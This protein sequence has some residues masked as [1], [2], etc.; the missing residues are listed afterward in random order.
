[1][2]SNSP[3]TKFTQQRISRDG[4]ILLSIG[5]VVGLALGLLIGW[6]WWPVDWQGGSIGTA[7][8][9]ERISYA[10]AVADAYAPY[11][12]QE[13]L[14]VAGQRLA[15]L[16]DNRDEII[17]QAIEYY[18]TQPDGSIQAANLAALASAL[19]SGA[20]LL[21]TQQ[22]ATGEAAPAATAVAT[23]VVTA[24]ATPIADTPQQDNGWGG[25]AR[26]L[27][28]LA[29]LALIGFGGYVLWMLA[30][31]RPLIGGD[32][33]T[34]PGSVPPEPP[35]NATRSTISGFDSGQATR[36][37]SSYA[38]AQANA[39]RV[40]PVQPTAGAPTEPFLHEDAVDDTV[41][42]TYATASAATSA[43]PAAAPAPERPAAVPPVYGAGTNNLDRYPTIDQ[44]TAEYVAGMEYFDYSKSIPG[45]PNNYLGE[46]GVGISERHGVLNSD[47]DQVVAME[48][49][50]FDKSDET[51][52]VDVNRVL[53]SEY[54]HDHLLK[55]F[56]RDKERY[57]PI[58]AQ[59]NTAFELNGRQL[60][61]KC[62]VREVVYSTEGIFQ[63]LVV[64]MELKKKG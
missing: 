59:R 7:S 31:G 44:Y 10:S 34:S 22:E 2:S 39:T 62:N 36:S 43:Q 21:T 27:A 47:R 29:G 58:V 15:S 46:Y 52:L 17:Q 51:Q 9:Q 35:S 57:G 61:L 63:R 23:A 54:A 16:G 3:M 5:V 25:F 24:I 30:K 11:S 18:S 37:S 32:G 26:I 40:S 8:N 20:E 13:A 33:G 50:L 53:L 42:T 4:V 56:E 38:Q 12:S 6:V 1:M 49:Y 55:H 41:V 60:V 45:G 14:T 48:I 28:L 64:D 19:A